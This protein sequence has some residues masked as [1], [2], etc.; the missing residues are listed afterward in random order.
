MLQKR[1]SNWRRYYYV[2]RTIFSCC[3]VP[4]YFSAARLDDFPTMDPSEV[5]WSHIATTEGPR[6]GLEFVWSNISKSV[7][8]LKHARA[9]K[10]S[11]ASRIFH[12]ENGHVTVKPLVTLADFVSLLARSN[13]RGPL[14]FTEPNLDSRGAFLARG[15]QWEVFSDGRDIMETIIIK[16]VKRPS[17]NRCKDA[18]IA[19]TEQNAQSKYDSIRNTNTVASCGQIPR[20]HYSTAVMGL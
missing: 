18:K 14:H 5:V 13:V 20:K 15:G 17:S 10:E 11:R 1:K 16:R 12:S 7:S 8:D 19:F 9:M 2:P 4:C 3:N 6:N